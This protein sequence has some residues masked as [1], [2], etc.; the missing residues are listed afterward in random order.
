MT[1]TM[2]NIDLN[3]VPPVGEALTAT[4]EEQAELT[5]NEPLISPDDG[6]VALSEDGTATE[7]EPAPPAGTARQIGATT[8]APAEKLFE[9][10]PP[11]M[12]Q[13]GTPPADKKN[14]WRRV[15]TANPATVPTEVREQ[16][17]ANDAG[18]SPE[19]REYRLCSTIN[20]SWMADHG[21]HSH[22]EL[23]V[24]WGK[25]RA[26]LAKELGVA[27]DEREVFVA[28]SVRE[29]EAERR[30]LA[31]KVYEQAYYSAL[32]DEGSFDIS[33]HT[34]E[35]SPAD[36]QLAAV[37]A[38]K[39]RQEGELLRNKW[40][41]LAQDLADSF[42][43]FYTVENDFFSLPGVLE[44]A[45][46]FVRAVD[47]LG[48]L[49]SEDRQL[50]SYLAAD[51]HRKKRAAADDVPEDE[52][53][54]SRT[55]RA[56]RRGSGHIGF[57]VLQ[58]VN[59][60]GVATLDN[61]GEAL[62][63][64][65]GASLR[66]SS[67]AW[68]K[69][70][71]VVNEIRHL[72][73]QGAAPLVLPGAGEAETFFL[74]AAQAV[75]SA[76]LSCYGGAGIVTLTLSSMGES[77]AEARRRA[78][79]GAQKSQ[80]AAG[81]AAGAAQGAIYMM[82]NRAGAA[83]FEHTLGK[84]LRARG[85]GMVNFGLKTGTALTTE[86]AK[87]MLA[88]KVATAA[89]L[90]V[91][92]ATAQV[93]GSDSG[94]D[95]KLYGASVLDADINM[96]E[97]AA[98]LPFLLIGAG[99]AALQ[100][101]RSVDN[102]LGSGRRL[103]EWKVEPEKVDAILRERRIDVQ[104]DMLREAVRGSELY[105][106]PRYS[107]DIVRAY[108]LLNI[109][110][111]MPN[112]MR[113]SIREFLNLSS[114]FLM[115]TAEQMSAL[116]PSQRV[117]DAHALRREWEQ[118]AALD[119]TQM[120]SE[121]TD[122]GY[123]NRILNGAGRKGLMNGK[124]RYRDSYMFEYENPADSFTFLHRSGVRNSDMEDIRL[125]ILRSYSS[126]LDK[127]SYR[128]LLQ[129]YPQDMMTC[130]N[131][132]PL[133]NLI[134][135][136]DKTR[137][138]YLDMACG[139]VMKLAAGNNRAEVY[140][141][142]ATECGDILREHLQGEFTAGWLRAAPDE[143][144]SDIAT[145]CLRYDHK[146]MKDYEEMKTFYR[147]IHRTRVC[148]A[149]LA[150][151]LPMS[152]P[153][154]ESM[155]LGKSPAQVFEDY[156]RQELGYEP[157]V[158]V[159][160][161]LSGESPLRADFAKKSAQQLQL[162]TTMTGYEMEQSPPDDSGQVH[163]R[164]MCP[165]G[166][167][168]PWYPSQQALANSIA[169]NASLLFS[170]LGTRAE[171]HIMSDFYNPDSP[172]TL[173]VAGEKEYSGFDQL[174]GLAI[175]ELSRRWLGDAT[176]A[177]P[178]F[179][180]KRLYPLDRA[181]VRGT[182]DMPLVKH[183]GDDPVF[184]VDKYA[185]LTPTGL[186][187]S[188]FVVYWAQ[189]LNSGIVSARHLGDFLERNQVISREQ[190]VDILDIGRRRTPGRKVANKPNYTLLPRM[191]KMNIRMAEHMGKFTLLYFLGRMPQMDLPP[192]VLNWYGSQSFAPDIPRNDGKPNEEG[193]QFIHGH[194]DEHTMSWIN[195][196]TGVRLR[197]LAPQVQEY[198]TKYGEQVGDSLVDELLPAAFGD[199]PIVQL[200]QGWTHYLNGDEVFSSAGQHYWNLLRFPARSWEQMPPVYRHDIALELEKFCR[201]FPAPIPL[202][203]VDG[204]P[205][206]TAADAAIANLDAMLQLHPQ[207]H[208]VSYMN[209]ESGRLIEL[210]PQAAGPI[211]EPAGRLLGWNEENE[212][213]RADYKVGVTNGRFLTEGSPELK[214]ALHTLDFLRAYP[215]SR[216]AYT[217][218]GSILWHHRRYGGTT[219]RHPRGLERWTPQDCLLDMRNMLW[220]EM[221]EAH[222]TELTSINCAG[223]EIPL[224]S[225]AELECPALRDITVY[226]H[227]SHYP[228]HSY[229]LMPGVADSA[230]PALRSPYVVGV[231]YGVYLGENDVTDEEMSMS[232]VP[233]SSY[234]PLQGFV[235]K[236]LAV[237]YDRYKL[238][239]SCKRRIVRSTLEELWA[240]ADDGTQV[241]T[242]PLAVNGNI[243]ELLMRLF[244]DTDFSKSLRGKTIEELDVGSLYALRLGA[245]MISCVAAPDSAGHGEAVSA[246]ERLKNTA[247]SLR[248]Y[249]ERL[250]QMIE[251]L[252]PD[253]K[254]K[255]K[256]QIPDVD[257]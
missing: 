215:K 156:L 133:A 162:Y 142:L 224:L 199:D 86:G 253:E 89:E 210:R 30:A 228:R 160:S 152:E 141:A 148:A 32:L 123:K 159:R 100:H 233:E 165:D 110:R 15:L 34:R 27:D 70:L 201:D 118:K 169:G 106:N 94:I 105:F 96:R 191:N 21:E 20:R 119:A 6:R 177:Q 7:A 255:K 196:Q 172:L 244:E 37:I 254:K 75:P 66:R 99:R 5:I 26:E 250:E 239:L 230:L 179:L 45:P 227:V 9:A 48:E 3:G 232:T 16:C 64:D 243:P 238:M 130:D 61:F 234:K 58:L 198:R 36:S 154:Q 150:D 151:F 57:G 257:D 72:A 68:D 209:S 23:M 190:K 103:L 192:S 17:G 114:D 181:L 67:A 145:R 211:Q 158:P 144:I 117:K 18:L 79:E 174:C 62:G 186:A 137:R 173:P 153:F 74:E 182:L 171:K 11:P 109:G 163:Y 38:E 85:F 134:A 10:E 51:L 176:H 53:L 54:A 212:K 207:L 115:P 226:R 124:G 217:P 147:L 107:A 246:Y 24:N 252:V 4:A 194:R 128:I 97:A 204:T 205:F 161:P 52:G 126:E 29:S 256:K 120:L 80:F 140:D 197:E 87:L 193:K 223:V 91:H 143:H 135:D 241:Y 127:C 225:Q 63:G 185:M 65:M 166:R 242:L 102:V 202:L 73:Q 249:P 245:D 8:D 2:N 214:Y 138:R 56:V 187:Y 136:A 108:R 218:D 125:Q 77:V 60:A 220:R 90:A 219:G 184:S 33:A 95:W 131:G 59:H 213:I 82:F 49:S 41:P 200:E 112:S 168:S 170:P 19:L 83:L 139:T 76:V 132:V 25:Y 203:Q 12:Q 14:Y 101:F 28:L 104:N 183:V 47:A 121:P 221:E 157:A 31:H 164:I 149:V 122:A 113:D 155:V 236:G 251:A 229:R 195:G 13:E 39:A 188:R 55:L 69:R 178:G 180:R 247:D 237:P 43:L 248:A 40:L 1:T 88:G 78:P 208:R 93:S 167:F 84:F 129:L 71:Q 111:N 44:S 50:V 175:G 235:Y 22:R 46:G 92:E 35:L 206:P 216:P 146:S 189:Q 98:M 240:I 231:R 81:V 42:D 222:G 116:S